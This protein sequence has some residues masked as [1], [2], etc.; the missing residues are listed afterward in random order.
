MASG[1]CSDLSQMPA[2][3]RAIVSEARRAV[4]ATVDGRGRP[5][6]VP[7]G[8]ALRGADVVTAVDQKPKGDRELTRV[9]NLR[10]H[11]DATMVMDRWDEDWRRLGWVMIRGVARIAAP[12]SATDELLERYPQYRNDPPRGVVIVLHPERIMW[13]M[14]GA[15][16]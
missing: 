14:W 16:H 15:G 11:P 7:V 8:F 5:H 2:D 12:G 3:V 4:L 9:A 13:W 6:A 1:A 10:A